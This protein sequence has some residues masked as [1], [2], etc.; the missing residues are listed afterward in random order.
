MFQVIKMEGDWWGVYLVDKSNPRIRFLVAGTFNSK[1]TADQYK[2]DFDR[3]AQSYFG[4]G[5]A[6]Y[7]TAEPATLPAHSGSMLRVV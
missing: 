3:I 7:H 1:G 5:Q 6:E 2:N 4:V